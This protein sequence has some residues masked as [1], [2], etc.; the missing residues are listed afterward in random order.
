MK[1]LSNLL[2]ALVFASLVIFMSC[3][4]GGGDDGPSDL[5]IAVD[6]L[7]ISG[8]F[9]NPT[10]VQTGGGTADGDW[11]TFGI[12][13][14]GSVD[15]GSYTVSNVPAGFEDVWA[16]GTWTINDAATVITRTQGG[17]DTDIVASIGEGSLTLEFDVAD[18]T[19]RTSGIAGEWTFVFN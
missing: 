18:P 12:T 9:S 7:T 2:A 19:A 8:G 3:G 16:N 10:T 4:G 15:G 13:F 14:T 1:Q 17:V 11:S 5:E 6:N